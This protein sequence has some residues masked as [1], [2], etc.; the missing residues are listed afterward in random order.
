MRN[1]SSRSGWLQDRD[2]LSRSSRGQVVSGHCCHLTLRPFSTRSLR[3]LAGLGDGGAALAEAMF[4]PPGSRD[5]WLIE[6]VR[7]V[8]ATRLTLKEVGKLHL[9]DLGLACGGQ[10]EVS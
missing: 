9:P 10:K 4:D 1:P 2:C 6:I 8:F 5:E 3:T 7:R